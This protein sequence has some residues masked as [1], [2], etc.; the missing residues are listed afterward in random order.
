[1]KKIAILVTILIIAIG[2]ACNFLIIKKIPKL[3]I[4]R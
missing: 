3:P 2:E 4:L 1:M